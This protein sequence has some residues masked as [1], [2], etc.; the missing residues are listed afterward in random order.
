[1]LVIGIDETVT[2]YLQCKTPIVSFEIPLIV[3]QN[4]TRKHKEHEGFVLNTVW[5]F[6]NVNYIKC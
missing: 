3:Y 2:T 5:I 1:M 6:R 4:N